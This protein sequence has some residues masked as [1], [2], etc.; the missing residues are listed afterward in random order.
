MLRQ[1]VLSNL[2]TLLLHDHG[3]K[4]RM[5]RAASAKSYGLDE[6]QY[7]K[8]YTSHNAVTVT[9]GGGGFLKGALLALVAS[10]IGATAVLGLSKYLE[11]PAVVI[12][13]TKDVDLGIEV[14]YEP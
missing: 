11:K 6:T 7:D 9:D 2:A 12:D 13:K 8:P 10:G 3:E 4:Q 5:T 1:K 14:E